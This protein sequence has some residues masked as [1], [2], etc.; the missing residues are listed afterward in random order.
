MSFSSELKE[1]LL[2]IGLKKYCCCKAEL[3]AFF[4]ST[5]FISPKSD[6]FSLSLKFTSLPPLRRTLL[7]LK[8]FSVQHEVLIWENRRKKHFEIVIPSQL[9]LWQL[10]N[11]LGL[12]LKK[13]FWELSP[14]IYKRECCKRSFLR[15]SFISSGSISLGS[16]GYHL[17]IRSESEEFLGAIDKICA[18][19]GIKPKFYRGSKKPFLYWK[20]FETIEEI[21]IKIGVRKALFKMENMKI[22]RSLRGGVNREVNCLTA[23]LSRTISASQKQIGDI[24][25]L[26]KEVGLES[27]PFALREIAEARKLYPHLSLVDLG[28]VFEPP[29]SK[30]AVYHRLRRIANLAQK[31]KSKR[32][33]GV[34]CL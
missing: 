24:N 20:D 8:P 2:T 4:L 15:A 17:E 22:L 21:L 33:E 25:F 31:I 14:R 7:F 11:E 26:E 9:K 19:W 13:S 18:D 29:L 6:N 34:K 27:L 32:K 30:S 10:F 5:G 3:A 1:E 28:K 23:N 16:N 12:E